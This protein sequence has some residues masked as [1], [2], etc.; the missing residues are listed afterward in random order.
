[1][2]I[3]DM[4]EIAKERGGLCLSEHYVGNKIVL[5]WECEIL[6][7]QRR[8]SKRKTARYSVPILLK[9]MRNFVAGYSQGQAVTTQ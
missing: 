9:R 7:A 1:M 3:E 2:T 5:Q 8:R 4:R 6:V